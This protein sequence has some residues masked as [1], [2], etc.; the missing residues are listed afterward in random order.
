MPPEKAIYIF[1]DEVL[2]PTAALMAQIYD[3]YKDEDGFLYVTYSG[4]NVSHFDW[5]REKSR[6]YIYVILCRPSAASRR[7]NATLILLPGTAPNTDPS[8]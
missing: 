8:I 3:D 6:A 1:V 2:P 5:G 4:E 7:R